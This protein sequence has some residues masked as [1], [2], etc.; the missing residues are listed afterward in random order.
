MFEPRWSPDGKKKKKKIVWV[1]HGN[2]NRRFPRLHLADCCNKRARWEKYG[3]RLTGAE[4]KRVPCPRYYLQR[5][6]T[7]GNQSRLDTRRKRKFSSSPT[8]ATSNGNRRLLADGK[9]NLA[10]RKAAAK[11][12]TKGKPAGKAHPDFSPDGLEHDLQ[13]LSR[14]PVA[15]NLW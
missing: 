2:G 14:P 7:L 10:P 15:K 13:L 8:A 5:L 12:I 3:A 9:R 6:R 11:F 4:N 1:S